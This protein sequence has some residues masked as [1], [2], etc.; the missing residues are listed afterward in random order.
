MSEFKSNHSTIF[1]QCK[2]CFT[3]SSRPRIKFDNQGVCNACNFYKKQNKI[4]YKKREK[5]L[6]DI[7]NNHRSCDG[8][9]D[10][11]V[12][13]SGGKDSSTIAYKLK[14]KYGMNPLLV[15][16]APLLQSNVGA[17]NRNKFLDL[18]FDNIIC[19]PNEQ[20]SKYLSKRFFIERGDPKVHWTA[21]IK[22][23]PIKEALEKNIKLIFYAENGE[24]FYGGNVLHEDAEKRVHI[25][26]IIENKIGDD[27]RNWEDD[28]INPENLNPYLLPE[29]E[30]VEKKR[31]EIYYFAYFEPWNI[32][33]NF[34]FISKKMNFL[35]H[36]DGRS[37]GTFT[38]FDSLD[39]H[40]DQVYYYMQLLKFG[41]GRAS[42]DAS[43]LIQQSGYKFKDLKKKVEDYDLETPTSDIMKYCE[44][45]SISVDE[46]NSICDKHREK[47]IWYYKGNSWK[48]KNENHI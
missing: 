18:G 24:C 44:F 29:V 25:E 21:G 6:A 40:V 2:N 47:S 43:R 36:K 33:D 9:Y 30:Q 4:N 32:E 28:I 41:F 1:K 20:V 17:I 38:N 15:T 39:D 7:C 42:R 10:C 16:F 45:I 27:P 14:Y 23:F 13:W 26:E 46:F 35:V 37:P 12:P 3:P 34:N 22:A 8:S 5:E 19:N 11:I 48:L 31:M